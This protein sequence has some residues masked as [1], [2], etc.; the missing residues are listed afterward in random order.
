MMEALSRKRF[1]VGNLEEEYEPICELGKGGFGSVV[2]ARH[3]VTGQLVAIKRLA[4]PGECQSEVMR[5]KRFLEACSGNPFV[6]GFRGVVRAPDSMELRL[7]MDHVGPSLRDFLRLRRAEDPPVPTHTGLLQ[8]AK[9]MHAVHRVHRDIKPDNLLVS[10]DQNLVKICDL[11]L[12][13]HMCDAPPY[14]R[15]G[16]TWYMAPEVVLGKPDY[17]ALVDAWSLGCV[18]AELINGE[19]LFF[20]GDNNNGSEACQQIRAIIDVLGVP[21]GKAWPWFSTTPFAT[22]VLPRLR[23]RQRRS[24][25]RHKFPATVLSQQGFEVLSGLLTWNPDKRLTASAALKH[26]WF[27]DLNAPTASPARN[28][29]DLPSALPNMKHPRTMISPNLLHKR[30]KIQCA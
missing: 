19:V 26:P 15:A 23:H 5:E 22:G 28:K 9:R 2:K 7:V 12:A 1:A 10:A 29:E 13:L 21:D 17:D 11:G 24:L 20:P 6:V 4:D 8:G 16:T 14:E 30:R 27:D 3:R 18:M 25:L